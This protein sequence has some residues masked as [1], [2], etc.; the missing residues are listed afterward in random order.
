MFR[1][2]N[3]KVFK[4]KPL[5]PK[6]IISLLSF[7]FLFVSLTSW[8]QETNRKYSVPEIKLPDINGQMFDVATLRGK[9]VLVE[10][11]ASW[12][13]PCRIQ[14]P[15]LRKIYKKFHDKDFEI[16]AISLDTDVLK[17]KKAVE[18]DKLTWIHLGD[19][20]SG[21]QSIAN[22]WGINAIPFNFLIDKEGKIIA[23]DL[24]PK[25]LGRKLDKL[26]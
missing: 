20:K 4:S 14:N 16:V 2:E 17:W 5:N 7:I 22:K 26:L 11:W 9:Y 8:A 13:G 24:K 3:I 19:L 25:E 21:E 10:F 12:C 23:Y 15:A 18:K 1:E 6:I